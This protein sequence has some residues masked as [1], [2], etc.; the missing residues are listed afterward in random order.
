[1]ILTSLDSTCTVLFEL[2][3][4]SKRLKFL[5]RAAEKRRATTKNVILWNSTSV[6]QLII[7][8]II[9]IIIKLSLN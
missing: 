2:I 4:F 8:I 3:L 6:L 7:I 9:I 1:V 5:T